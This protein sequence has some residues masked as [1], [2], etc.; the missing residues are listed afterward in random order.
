MIMYKM[1]SKIIRNKGWSCTYEIED[2]DL[3]YIEFMK[4]INQK[5]LKV[6]VK[7]RGKSNT[8]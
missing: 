8:N 3:G 6:N 4:F 1:L 2:L 5:F 7:S